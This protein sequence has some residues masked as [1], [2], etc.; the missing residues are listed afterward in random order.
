MQAALDV[1]GRGLAVAQHDLHRL[2]VKV[3][4]VGLAHSG[5][6]E[7]GIAVFV[8]VLRRRHG[9]EVLRRALR[10]EMA[11]DFLDL[12]VGAKW[13]VHPADAA[14]TGHVEHVALPEE[15]F[16]ALLS[17]NGAAI[18][19]R[20]DLERDAGREIGLDRAG[21]DVDRRP[22]RREDHV[23]AGRARHLGKAL[24]GAF[25]VL[26]GHHHQVGHLVHDDDDVR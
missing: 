9:V 1:A 22:L 12:L 13:S 25:D 19:L 14:A 23:Q 15:L 4:A 18:D 24:H 16:G 21:D 3:A 26:A 5:R 11:H 20:R 8:F 17:Q 7:D 10:F 6:V 2:L